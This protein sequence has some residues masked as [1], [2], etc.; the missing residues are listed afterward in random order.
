MYLADAAFARQIKIVSSC[1]LGAFL[2]IYIHMS[3]RT[4]V[5]VWKALI[6]NFLPRLPKPHGNLAYEGFLAYARRLSDA[7]KRMLRRMLTCLDM[8]DMVQQDYKLTYALQTTRDRKAT[9][10]RK[11]TR[12]TLV[13]LGIVRRGD[14]THIHHIDHNVHN[15]RLSNLR[16]VKGTVHKREH[17]RI[18]KH[19][20]ATCSEFIA[21]PALR[22][23]LA[24]AKRRP[25]RP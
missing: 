18:N 1:S 19:A 3:K 24:K 10:A 4:I 16:I 11:R 5:R 23:V 25:Q 14:G 13:A 9:A 22:R 20:T 12:D 2:H 6:V 15:N 7:N 17:A 8:R 21:Q